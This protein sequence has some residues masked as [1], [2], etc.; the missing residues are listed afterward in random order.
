MGSDPVPFNKYT[1][2]KMSVST[3]SLC[4]G[5]LECA[6]VEEVSMKW[7]DRPSDTWSVHPFHNDQNSSKQKF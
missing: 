6:L 5:P 1:Y 2:I 3:L 4:P 7:M